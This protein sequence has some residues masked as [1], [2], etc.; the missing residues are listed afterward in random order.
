MTSWTWV[1][2]AFT[3]SFLVWF[4]RRDTFFNVRLTLT[5]LYQDEAWGN[6]HIGWA[7]PPAPGSFLSLYLRDFHHKPEVL[8][9]YRLM[10]FKQ[11]IMSQFFGLSLAVCVSWSAF[12][13]RHSLWSSW[14]CGTAAVFD[15]VDQVSLQSWCSYTIYYWEAV[16]CLSSYDIILR[17]IIIIIIIMLYILGHL[18]TLAGCGGIA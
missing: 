6:C 1:A 11:E 9:Q 16:S 4:K 14:G 18:I 5:W 3:E 8:L 12:F 7:I 15:F 17:I 10:S 2:K 13:H